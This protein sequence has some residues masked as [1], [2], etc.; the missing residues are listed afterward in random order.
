MK[1]RIFKAI[2]GIACA[3]ALV[4]AATA[5]VSC[6]DTTDDSGYPKTGT[7]YV[8]VTNDVYGSAGDGYEESSFTA[9]KI[10]PDGYDLGTCDTVER[11]LNL[12]HGE[13]SEPIEVTGT[14]DSFGHLDFKVTVTLTRKGT[15]GTLTPVRED[16]GTHL[17]EIHVESQCNR[18]IRGRN[19]WRGPV[20]PAHDNEVP[21]GKRR[22][23]LPAKSAGDW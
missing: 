3:L 17:G 8:K 13:I 11:T 4:S 21:A 12:Q 22:G 23:L 5:L 10:E 9:I 16:S 6:D 18:G 1:S 14:T 15:S 19:L 20:G 2:M 7:W